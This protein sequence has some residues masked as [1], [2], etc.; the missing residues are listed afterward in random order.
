MDHNHNNTQPADDLWDANIELRGPQC[1]FVKNHRT[2][3]N[4]S[5]G[6]S[7]RIKGR[8]RT[9]IEKRHL[10]R[11]PSKSTSKHYPR[12]KHNEVQYEKWRLISIDFPP[13]LPSPKWNHI[14][15]S[16]KQECKTNL[17][18]KLDFPSERS[19][20]RGQNFVHS[21]NSKSTS[22]GA[23]AM[24]QDKSTKLI[25][26]NNPDGIYTEYPASPLAQ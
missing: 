24:A 19:K 22:I 1:E 4:S 23:T 25:P 11:S 2:T 17:F 20:R 16:A 18:D 7:T 3:I 21:I 26:L 6:A 14:D 15:R 8:V 10:R 5:L 9:S 12:T 13:E